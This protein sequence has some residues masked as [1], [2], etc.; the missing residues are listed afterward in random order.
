MGEGTELPWWEFASREMHPAQALR[1]VATAIVWASR[2]IDRAS[3]FPHESGIY[4][5][6]ENLRCTCP[7]W[8]GEVMTFEGEVIYIG[9]AIDLHHRWQGHKLRI[10][11]ENGLYTVRWKPL[12]KDHYCNLEHEESTYIGIFAPKLN[13][14]MRAK[15]P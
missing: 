7:E 12:D 8:G 11:Y 6:S 13:R 9:K 5:V 14:I 2:S 15:L 1:N 4:F 10:G 3:G